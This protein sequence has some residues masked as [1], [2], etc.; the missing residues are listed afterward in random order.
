MSENIA[1]A[2]SGM[3]VLSSWLTML[4]LAILAYLLAQIFTGITDR[5]PKLRVTQP[6]AQPGNTA[7]PAIHTVTHTVDNSPEHTCKTQEQFLSE[8]Q[9]EPVFVSHAEI[10]AASNER[11]L[12]LVGSDIERDLPPLEIIFIETSAGP[13]PVMSASSENEVYDWARDPGSG[14]ICENTPTT[15]VTV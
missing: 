13:R 14:L 8:T 12:R 1:F 9:F 10:E 6:K 15:V 3:T 4:L 5:T 11:K 7:S 2:A